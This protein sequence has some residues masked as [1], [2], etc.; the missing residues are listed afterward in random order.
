MSWLKEELLD[1]FEIDVVRRYQD[2]M[3]LLGEQG[4]RRMFLGEYLALQNASMPQ[5]LQERFAIAGHK[6]FAN[7]KL[8]ALE[9]GERR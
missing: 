2:F 4:A 6:M 1:S 8:P 7:L 9:H 5:E 3:S